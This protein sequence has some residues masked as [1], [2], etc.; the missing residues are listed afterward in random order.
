MTSLNIKNEHLNL[1]FIGILL[2]D[3]SHWIVGDHD[4]KK[5]WRTDKNYMMRTVGVYAEK[6]CWTK[7][8][9]LCI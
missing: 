3:C 9:I 6:S 5:N 1:Q 7:R 2:V 8:I 4:F